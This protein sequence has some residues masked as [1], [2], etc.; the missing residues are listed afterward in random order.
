MTMLLSSLPKKMN[1]QGSVVEG[2]SRTSKPLLEPCGI[3]TA[4]Q[5]YH[6]AQLQL[7]GGG[8]QA[9]EQRMIG[10]DTWMTDKR[11][12]SPT[13]KPGIAKKTSHRRRKSFSSVAVDLPP[14]KR[15]RQNWLGEE[16]G[17]TVRRMRTSFFSCSLKQLPGTSN[18]ERFQSYISGFDDDWESAATTARVAD[19]RH[20]L[21][22]F[23]QFKNLE[24]DTLRRA[25][26]STAMILYHLHNDKAP[27]RVPTCTDCGNLIMD[28]RWHK[29]SKI[30]ERRRS[31]K[32]PPVGRKQTVPTPDF[33]PSDL[34]TACYSLKSNCE[35][36]IPLQVSMKP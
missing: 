27:G 1:K 7:I 25:K 6:K 10:N 33:E 31:T 8:P 9:V 26:Y 30:V 15:R 2:D 11:N 18:M 21:L 20:A 19:M 22:E 3:P 13:K 34:C 12:T 29:I 23:C 24:F 4:T 35:H 36:F 5:S 16:V 32:H 17:S 14:L 28:V